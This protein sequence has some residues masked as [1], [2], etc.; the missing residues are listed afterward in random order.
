MRPLTFRSSQIAAIGKS[1]AV[2]EFNLD[3]TIIAAN[4][5]FLA[6]TGYALPEIKGQHHRMFVEPAERAGAA[7]AE[8]WAALNRGEF[9]GGEYKRVGK[10][11]KEI[12]LQATYNPIFDPAGR[13]YKVVKFCTDI[14]A[15]VRDRRTPV[16]VGLDPRVELLPASLRPPGETPSA[17]AASYIAFCRGVIDVVAALVP[18]VKPQAAFFEELGAAGVAALAEIIAYARDQGLIVI[19][20]AKRGDIGSTAEAYAR[21]MLG[22]QPPEFRGQV[23]EA[24]AQDTEAAGQTS[25]CEGLLVADAVTVNPYLGED[26]LEPFVDVATARDARRLDRAGPTRPRNPGAVLRLGSAFE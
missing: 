22:S 26:A 11:S 2:I 4:A 9:Q 16:L 6:A 18:A 25:E 5:N 13:P 12:W 7:Y 8:F 24:R 23:Y 1:Q 15:A 20:D 19:L 21:G 10:G 17:I 14:T 3:G